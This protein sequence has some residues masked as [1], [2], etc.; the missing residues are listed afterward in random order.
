MLSVDTEAMAKEMPKKSQTQSKGFKRPISLSP[1]ELEDEHS[2]LKRQKTPAKPLFNEDT[3][4]KALFLRNPSS[5]DNTFLTENNAGY[6]RIDVDDDDDDDFFGLKSHLADI[7]GTTGG[8]HNNLDLTSS[9]I[10]LTDNSFAE[11]GRRSFRH[12]IPQK[13]TKQTDDDLQLSSPQHAKQ[14]MELKEPGKF[15]EDNAINDDLEDFESWL[16][17]GAVEIID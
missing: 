6:S 11:E 16:R 17:S 7:T 14:E 8:S 5:E 15:D 3:L 12:G 10:T 1:A 4:N 2:G 13:G 9:S